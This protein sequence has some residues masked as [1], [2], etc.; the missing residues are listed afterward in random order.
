MASAHRGSSGGGG[1]GGG[2]A[3]RQ[4][5]TLLHTPPF[6][7]VGKAAHVARPGWSRFFTSGSGRKG[8]TATATTDEVDCA[9][10]SGEW[11]EG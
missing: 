10:K 9:A 2:G 3:D 11:P 6:A 1:D 7:M 4:S 8:T 5:P